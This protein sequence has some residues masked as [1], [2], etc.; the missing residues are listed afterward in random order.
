M[1]YEIKNLAKTYGGRN[2]LNL[3]CSLEKGK[4]TGLLGPNGAGKTTLLE[5]LAFLSPPT[6]GDI[7]FNGSRIDFEKADLVSLRKGAVLLQQKPILFTTTVHDN[8]EFPLKIRKI[9]KVE[10]KEKINQ[11]LSLVGMERFSH[12]GA[13]KLSGGE[14]QRVAIAQALACSP[15]VILMDEPTSSVDVENQIIIEGIIKEINRSKGISVIFTTHDRTQASRIADKILFL[16]EG[17]ITDSVNENLFSGAVEKDE[18]GNIF[19]IIQNGLKIPVRTEKTGRVRIS[20]SPDGVKLLK[21]IDN[22]EANQTV[23]GKVIQLTD[24]KEY[25]RVLID[26]GVPLSIIMER[27]VNTTDLPCIGEEVLL[28]FDPEKVKVF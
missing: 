3:T 25:I 13:H 28:A 12:A 15:E 26:I 7:I 14:T 5:I 19:C 18:M 4:V 20:I 17:R 24:E 9:N 6:S 11:L 10:R 27:K 8:L 22:D 16:H 2:V 23:K 21:I 1:L